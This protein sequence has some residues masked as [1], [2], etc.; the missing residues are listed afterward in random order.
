M[1]AC[2]ETL[3][4]FWFTVYNAGPTSHHHQSLA[5]DTSRPTVLNSLIT[6]IVIFSLSSVT[7]SSSVQFLFTEKRD[8][9]AYMEQMLFQCLASFADS[10]PTL[11]QYST[12]LVIFGWIQCQVW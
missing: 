6:H 1:E 3:A 12:K 4:K 10:G 2:Q 8:R 7:I 9:G 5:Y 11:N